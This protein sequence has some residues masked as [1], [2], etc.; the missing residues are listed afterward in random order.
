MHEALRCRITRS[1]ET[2]PESKLCQ[3]LDYI[4]FLEYQ[5]S[6]RALEETP[7]LQNLAECLEDGLSSRTMSPLRPREAFQFISVV[8]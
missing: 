6:H 3:V 7:V 1:L 8:D 5:C 4:E 2:P